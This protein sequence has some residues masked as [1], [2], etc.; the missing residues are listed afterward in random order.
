MSPEIIK[1]LV[2]FGIGG[3]ALFTVAFVAVAPASTSK[4]TVTI[5]AML[6]LL[7]IYGIER[8][9]TQTPTV[10]PL[11]S[12]LNATSADPPDWIDTGI[13]ADWGARDVAFT[14]GDNPRY[15]V[16]GT[17]LCDEAHEGWVSVCW[18]N[19]PIGYPDRSL[20]ND[21]NGSPG[22]WCTYKSSNIKL[23]TPPDGG[24]IPSRVYLC[25]HRIPR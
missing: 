11:P 1:A 9:I 25:A 4:R 12:P 18:N 8:W 5:V 15:S 2:P 17:P 19:R 7:A 6:I 21:V 22:K 13:S 3:L 20:L 10:S 24:A 16:R 23:S 14:S